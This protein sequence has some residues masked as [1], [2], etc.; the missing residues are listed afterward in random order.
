MSLRLSAARGPIW[1][2]KASWNHKGREEHEGPNR[3]SK[4]WHLNGAKI[5]AFIIDSDPLSF[6]FLFLS[7]CPWCPSWFSS[8]LRLK[9]R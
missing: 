8:L 4:E 1:N 7:L 2:H 9:K 6:R 3:N 5:L